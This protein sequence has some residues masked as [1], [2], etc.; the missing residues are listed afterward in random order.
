MKDIRFIIITVPPAELSAR[1]E[2]PRRQAAA[3]TGSACALAYPPHVTLRTGALVPLRSVREFAAG[4]RAALGP[5]RPFALRTEGVFHSPYENGDGGLKHM[6]GWRVV[7]DEPLLKLH[8]DLLSFERFRRRAQASF[9]PHLTL[10]F[11][12]LQEDHALALLD[13]ARSHPEVFPPELSWTC[14]NVGLYREWEERW[15]P[16]IEFHA[17]EGAS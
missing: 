2:A 16:Y 15:E 3:L 17:P 10:A 8:R 5:W 9:E 11:D 14:S 13:H 6:V 1:L 7:V 12:D 4:V